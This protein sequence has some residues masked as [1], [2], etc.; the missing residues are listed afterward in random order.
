LVL[1]LTVDDY[2]L[3]NWS[4]NGNH[5]ALALISGLTLPPLALVSFWLLAVTVARLPGHLTRRSGSTVRRTQRAS[6]R[7]APRNAGRPSAEA[8]RAAESSSR[9]LAA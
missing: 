7:A 1:G 8:A 4:L 9:K 6:R 3:W 2:V 5:D